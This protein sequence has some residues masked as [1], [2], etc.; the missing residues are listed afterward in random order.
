ME[1]PSFV[2]HVTR[3]TCSYCIAF[4][5]LRRNANKG[6]KGTMYFSRQACFSCET[7]RN[8]FDGTALGQRGPQGLKDHWMDPESL[9]LEWRK[10]QW[11]RNPSIDLVGGIPT[12]LKNDGVSNSW[13]YDSQLNGKS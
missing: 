9:S 1:D 5:C 8:T 10:D 7:P 12:P 2:D 11:D 3:L 6:T 13:D 4:P